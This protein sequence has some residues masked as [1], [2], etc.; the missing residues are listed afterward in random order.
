MRI[1]ILTFYKVDNFG[2]NLQA[3]STY[4]NL[5]EKGHTPFLIHYES[6]ESQNRKLKNQSIQSKEHLNFLEKFIPNQTE[7]CH[8]SNDIIN[9]IQKYNIEA[10]II[11]SDAVVQHHPIWARIH[12]GKRKPFYI[13]KTLPETTFPNSFWG[14]G[15]PETIPMAMMSV[16]SQNSEYKLFSKSL[17]E[18]MR[19]ALTRMKYIS[20]RDEW[21]QKMIH[22]IAND[23]NI[24][25][26]PDP[27]FA[28]NQNAGQFIPSESEIRKKYSLPQK[29]VLVSLH[30][31]SLSEQQLSE[32]KSAFEEKGIECIAFTMPT[33][34]KFKHP[35]K[36]QI[37]IPLPPE[38]WY[39][40]LKYASAYVGSNMHPIVVCLHNAIPCFSIDHWGTRNFWGHHKNDGSSKV[41]H[42]LKVFGLQDYIVPIDIDYCS[43]SPSYIVEKII[44]FPKKEVLLKSKE[45]TD[46]YEK[47]MS[48]ILTYLKD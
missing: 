22:I 28:F 7:V 23:L 29:Y 35:F 39:A 32:L 18:K 12:K 21:T 17:K 27:V 10:I 14:I 38:D 11:G 30:S 24:P 6:E 40:L 5:I 1:G 8:A 48:K 33:G 45:M 44:S 26:T 47:M 31:Q 3:V 41:N 20:V 37:D 19:K 2:A 43:V 16:S 4:Y 42:I 13:T 15:I 25:I 36:K 9:A 46:T 34:I